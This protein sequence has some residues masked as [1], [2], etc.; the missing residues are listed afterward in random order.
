MKGENFIRNF[1]GMALLE[2]GMPSTSQ[3]VRIVAG[4]SSFSGLERERVPVVRN[5]AISTNLGGATGSRR[6]VDSLVIAN[7]FGTINMPRP[8]FRRNATFPVSKACHVSTASYSLLG[9]S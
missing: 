7:S 5:A 8:G 3:T 6:Y 4:I 2:K 9:S 1:L